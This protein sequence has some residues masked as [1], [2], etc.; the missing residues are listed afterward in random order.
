[1][2]QGA[3]RLRAAADGDRAVLGVGQRM[4]GA[5]AAGGARRDP[6]PHRL[7]HRTQPM[8]L[9]LEVDPGDRA[10]RR[11]LLRAVRDLGGEHRLR[12]GA[13]DGVPRKRGALFPSLRPPRTDLSLRLRDLR[14]DDA[15]VSVPAGRARR[16]PSQGRSIRSQPAQQPLRAGLF[17][18]DLYLLH[19]LRLAAQL[20]PA[21]DPARR[22]VAGGAN[23]DNFAGR[24]FA[25]RPQAT[26]G[27]LRRDRG[28]SNWRICGA[29]AAG[30][31]PARRLA[32]LPPAPDRVLY[33]ACWIIALGAVL[34]AIRRFD[35]RRAAASTATVAVVFLGYLYIFAMPDR[36]S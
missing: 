23:P 31:D 19:A 8:A 14:P 28:R 35:S 16:S 2:D 12:E 5:L 10:G 27:G 3:T 34:Y 4:G 22:R 30:V 11:H 1:A 26:S 36:K 7:A 20:L 32:A 9:Q 25:A 17:L 24:A 6:G 29:A 33:A 21:A 15:V 13:R 18:G